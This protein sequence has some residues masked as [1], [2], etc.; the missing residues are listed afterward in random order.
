MLGES[1]LDDNDKFAADGVWMRNKMLLHLGNGSRNDFFMDLAG[2]FIGAPAALL[3]PVHQRNPSLFVTNGDQFLVV[4]PGQGRF[5]W[6][7]ENLEGP[8]KLDTSP[9]YIAADLEV[10][11]QLF[12]LE[13]I[14]DLNY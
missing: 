9:Q 11:G 7:H 1:G 8:G 2:Q 6:R 13:L 12:L 14:S 5:S 3:G 4:G 10:F